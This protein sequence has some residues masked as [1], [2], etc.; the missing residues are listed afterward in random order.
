MLTEHKD[1]RE[2]RRLRE[3]VVEHRALFEEKW[4]EHFSSAW[5]PGVCV[6]RLGEM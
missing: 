6:G 4:H 5:P 2:L 1:T 3:L